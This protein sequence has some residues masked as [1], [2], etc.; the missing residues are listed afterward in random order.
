MNPAGRDVKI[1][2]RSNPRRWTE[3]KFWI[4]KLL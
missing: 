4:F 2:F 3:Q 1:H